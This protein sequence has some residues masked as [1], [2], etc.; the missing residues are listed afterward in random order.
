MSNKTKP[1]SA[2]AAALFP[3]SLTAA[4]EHFDSPQFES[5]RTE[6][7]EAANRIQAQQ[8]GNTQMKTDFDAAITRADTAE[9]SLA[10]ATASL[11]EAEKKAADLAATNKQLQE[12]HDNHQ[13]AMKGTR[14]KEDANLPEHIAGLPEN[15]PNRLAVE[16]AARREAKK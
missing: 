4:S 7:E 15:H 13:Q 9:A 12:W 2:A 3:K 1:I 10:T 8:D 14:Q 5:F 11:A 6:A 16:A